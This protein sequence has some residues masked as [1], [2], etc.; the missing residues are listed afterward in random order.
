MKKHY[1]NLSETSIFMQLLFYLFLPPK[2]DIFIL[3]LTSIL[4]CRN[5][6][7]EV[8]REERV[9]KKEKKKSTFL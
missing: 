6:E 3:L 5:D 2:N 4:H 7:G 1:N 9:E 8:G